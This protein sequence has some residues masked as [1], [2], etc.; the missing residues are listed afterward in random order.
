[1]TRQASQLKDADRGPSLLPELLDVEQVGAIC[2]FSARHVL[3]MVDAGRMPA[4]VKVGRC[5]RW[6]RQA[7]EAWVAAG[8]PRVDAPSYGRRD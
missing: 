7:I 3:R 6:S 2:Q 1:M 5:V 4:P 8:C